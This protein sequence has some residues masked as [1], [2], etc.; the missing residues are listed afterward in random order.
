MNPLKQP[1]CLKSPYSPDD[2]RWTS[3]MGWSN[4]WT[5]CSSNELNSWTL[6][7]EN[8][9]E[10]MYERASGMWGIYSKNQNLDGD[11]TEYFV[12]RQTYPGTTSL[13]IYNVAIAFMIGYTGEPVNCPGSAYIIQ[14]GNIVIYAYYSYDYDKTF[15][16]VYV[17]DETV[18]EIEGIKNIES[19]E[20]IYDDLTVGTWNVVTLDMI[21]KEVRFYE[22]DNY[23]DKVELPSI[24]CSNSYI[25]IMNIFID[26]CGSG[27]GEGY[28]SGI[29]WVKVTWASNPPYPGTEEPPQTSLIF[30]EDWSS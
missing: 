21:N 14:T 19:G 18:G 10:D 26:Y 16:E 27:G 22:D 23:I 9:I 12:K 30:T 15:I 24:A 28:V 13:P 11:E 20:T 2:P 7:D 25:T 5:Y 3:S 6:L 4:V 1:Y 8:L 17:V 29:D